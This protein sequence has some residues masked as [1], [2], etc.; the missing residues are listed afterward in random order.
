MALDYLNGDADDDGPQ[1][2]IPRAT[3][4]Q[5]ASPNSHHPS[6]MEQRFTRNPKPTPLETPRIP[7]AQQ[8]GLTTPTS[9]SPQTP[10]L[11]SALPTRHVSHGVTNILDRGTSTSSTRS[12]SSPADAQP[13]SSHLDQTLN[14][15]S[16]TPIPHM[17]KSPN[18]AVRDDFKYITSQARHL[19]FDTSP[20]FP[21]TPA[22]FAALRADQKNRAADF[23]KTEIG[24]KEALRSYQGR[25]RK[26]VLEEANRVLN[27]WA[28][29]SHAKEVGTE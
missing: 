11:P 4:R 19:G 3:A 24:E 5:L 1:S 23:L 9:S 29:R 7:L 10:I 21:E 26:A 13:Q 16:S 17:W 15:P 2:H 20:A 28:A 8:L 6:L 27:D 14:P 18:Q 22:Q 25:A 12:T